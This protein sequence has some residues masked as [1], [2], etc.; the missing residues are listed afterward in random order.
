MA[1]LET[2]IT[3][4]DGSGDTQIPVGPVYIDSS[5]DYFVMFTDLGTTPLFRV[6][7]STDKG[8]TWSNA[9]DWSG[10]PTG[11]GIGTGE[12]RTTTQLGD[13]IYL[14]IEVSATAVE[15]ELYD[16]STETWGTGLGGPTYS[17][18][19]SDFNPSVVAHAS[20]DI[21]LF[22]KLYT[23]KVMGTDYP[24]ASWSHYNGSVW[25]TP[26][27]CYE[28]NQQTADGEMCQAV[29][30]STGRTHFCWGHDDDTDGLWLTV[31]A[32]LTTGQVLGTRNTVEAEPTGS[33][34]ELA[35][36]PTSLVFTNLGS[37]E[38]IHFLVERGGQVSTGT[39]Y[40]RA[41]VAAAISS[42]TTIVMDGSSGAMEWRGDWAAAGGI[43][44]FVGR[45]LAQNYELRL[46]LDLGIDAT[47][48]S[49]LTEY[50]PAYTMTNNWDNSHTSVDTDDG[51]LLTLVRDAT[52]T[53]IIYL[54]RM[55]LIP[56][57]TRFI[58]RKTNFRESHPAY[59][60]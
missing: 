58:N 37:T 49:D 56:T 31:H 22:G 40:A 4:Y 20:N 23:D 39:V 2:P 32:A 35:V 21:V 29:A 18:T 13:V 14:V 30:D 12:P 1:Q 25:S 50:D 5:G 3:I 43:L 15:V 27:F 51:Y 59:T 46:S 36:A 28:H 16:M 17:D 9:G 10:G 42:W 47:V 54:F 7:K 38:Q 52:D 8:L 53:D 57:A 34:A 55:P 44:Y 26:A 45:G 11:V 60:E 19:A 33:G 48:E 6:R 41:T 24:M